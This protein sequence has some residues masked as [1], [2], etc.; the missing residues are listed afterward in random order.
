MTV[1]LVKGLNFNSD[2]CCAKAA[3]SALVWNNA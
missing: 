1:R 2:F 3:L